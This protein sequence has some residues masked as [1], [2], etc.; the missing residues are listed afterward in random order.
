MNHRRVA[1][2]IACLIS[3]SMAGRAGAVSLSL[4]TTTPQVSLG[5]LVEVDVVI[6]GLA[7]AAAP[8]LGSFD[9]DVSADSTALGFQG[10]TFSLLLGDPNLGQ[11]ITAAGAIGTTV[12]LFEL[13]L[14]LPAELD[15]L[16]PDTFTLAK[17]TFS[18]DEA[19]IIN[20]FFTQ[21]SLGDAFGQ[22]FPIDESVGL[23]IEVP[24]PGLLPLLLLG[25]TALR[26]SLFP[27]SRRP[28]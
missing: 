12:D 3:L 26:R 25:S 7:S 5:S 17:I 18:A 22:L 10:A 6:S 13:S 24:E 8:S 11:A 20:L 28:L 21:D 9:L 2:A 23:A 15:A 4:V 14:L 16:Q 1:L 19:G 27:R